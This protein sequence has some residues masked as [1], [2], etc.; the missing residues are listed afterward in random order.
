M[1]N[2]PE[3]NN[4]VAILFT[5]GVESYLLG[6]L[7]VQKY[8][9]D[10]VVFVAWNMDEYNIF[11]KN[12][13]KR[14]RVRADFYTSVSNVG[15]QISIVINNDKYQTQTGNMAPRTVKIIKNEYPDVDYVLG[16]YN[17]IHKESYEIF[18]LLDVINNRDGASQRGR[19]EVFSNRKKYP[20][21]LEFLT[22]CKGMVYFVEED[23][24]MKS[25]EDL[26]SFYE[27]KDMLAPFYMLTKTE[28]VKLY[29]EL[30]LLEDLWKSNSCNLEGHTKHCGLCRNCLARRVAIRNAGI[31]DKTEYLC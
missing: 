27:C 13:D 21:L 24:T 25:P 17:N 30:G 19:L 4:K 16:G 9:A 22:E 10:K 28:V 15:G 23:F 31:E 2:L 6:K 7:C 12:D 14:N 11:Y 18:E 8:G 3:T 26:A 1:I 5:G 29:Q 20:E